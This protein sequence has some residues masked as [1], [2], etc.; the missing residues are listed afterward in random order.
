VPNQ[1]ATPTLTFRCPPELR[2][3][4][5]RICDDRGITMTDY[6]VAALWRDVRAWPGA[7]D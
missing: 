3:A 4:I 1:P 5:E 2:E 6:I 7:I